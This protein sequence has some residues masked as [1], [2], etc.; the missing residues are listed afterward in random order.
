MRV[1]S[2]DL[3]YK[4]HSSVGWGTEAKTQSPPLPLVSESPSTNS[5]LSPSLSTSTENSHIVSNQTQKD[6]PPFSL[7]SE[8]R[9]SKKEIN[10]DITILSPQAFSLIFAQ[11]PTWLFSLEP[12][13]VSK[14]CFP[15]F[16]TKTSFISFLERNPRCKLFLHLIT[17]AFRSTLMI[18]GEILPESVFLI[19]GS[20]SFGEKILKLYNLFASSWIFLCD[21]VGQ[22]RKIPNSSSMDLHRARHSNFGGPT[23]GEVLWSCSDPQF[24]LASSSIHR[25]IGDFLDYS[26]RPSSVEC[27]CT[28]SCVHFSSLIPVRKLSSPVFYPSTYTR[29]GFGSR[30]LVSSELGLIF[31]LPKNFLQFATQSSF[32]FPPCQVLDALL[33][34][35]GVHSKW[36]SRPVR[37]ERPS[38]VLCTPAPVLDDEPTYLATLG[39]TL[40]DTWKSNIDASNAAAKADDAAINYSLWNERIIS[41][42][43]HA[44]GLLQPLREFILRSQKRRLYLEFLRYLRRTY[45]RSYELYLRSRN[46]LYASAGSREHLRGGDQ[47][48]LSDLGDPNSAKLCNLRNDIEDGI[49]VLNSY[50]GSSF[51]AWDKGS[52]LIFWRWHHQ[53]QQIAHHGFNAQISGTL[54]SNFKYSRKPSKQVH[55]KLFSKIKKGMERSY[56]KVTAKSRIKNLIDYFAVPKAEDIRMVQNG[57]SCGLNEATWASNFW[58]PTS[59]SMIRV[60]GFNYKAIDIDLGEM[61]LNFP[62]D[63]SLIPYS[64]MDITPFI[65]DVK[66]AFP[67]LPLPDKERLFV[68]NTRCWMGLRPSPEWA[69]R[70]YYL[71]EEF[72]RG[73]E[74]DPSN[75]LF[76]DKVV[77]NLI[78]NANFNPSM[79]N[80]YKWNSA[81]KRIAGDI[82]AYVDDLRA[83][84]WSMEHAWQI[85]H[86]VASRL[87]YLGIQDA[88]R[89][90][91]ID[92]G[93]WAGCVYLTSITKVQRTVTAKKWKKGQD[94]IKELNELVY[95]KKQTKLDF[96]FLEKVRGFLC[97]I[98]MTFDILFPFLKGFHLTLCSYL[99]KR[100]GEGW[101]IRDL[102]W[103]AFLEQEKFEG[104]MTEQEVDSL[105]KF[106]YDPKNRPHQIIPVPR[107]YS[108]LKALSTFFSTDDPPV[109]TDRSSEVKLLVYGFVDASKSGFGA[110][111]DYNNHV[112]FRIGI[113]GSDEDDASSNFREFAN[114]VETLEKEVKENRLK[115]AT[116]IMATD[117]STVEAAIQKGNSSSEKLFDLVVRF[118]NMELTSGSKFLVTH[119]SGDRMQ[120]QGTDGISRGSLREGIS[121]GQSMLKFCPWGL[122]ALTRST[123]LKEWIIKLIGPEIEILSPDDWFRRGHDHLPGAKDD[124]GFYRLKIKS[125]T[126]LW[127]P[128][129]AAAD[130]ALEELRKARLK[131]RNSTHVLLI[132]KLVTTLWL[133]QL[134]KAADVVLTIPPNFDFWP[135]NM[136]EPLYLAFVFPYSRH[137][138]WQLRS[139]PKLIATQRSL[140]R[141]LRAPPVAPRD[142]LRKFYLSTKRIPTLPARLVRKVLFF[143]SN[144]PLPCAPS[145]PV[146]H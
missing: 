54:P 13:M 22:F 6:L 118:R 75:P 41:V 108:C 24:S 116:V 101:K 63:R 72:V 137:Y 45:G 33:R 62:L 57:S 142:L 124:Q 119:V 117:N 87:Q 135:S 92:N 59:S 80:V 32:P 100:S 102:E 109:I 40:P 31:G 67:N 107:F 128:P 30:S 69:C 21:K 93:P 20:I 143:E 122:S 7:E 111:L 35:F 58:L 23:N 48:I 11:P 84:G 15:Q 104:R 14:M 70:F 36:S 144:D 76:W 53:L 77:L 73:D 50:H 49:G 55:A 114:L 113:W 131:R 95:E 115:D 46:Y 86:L 79:P 146:E 139:T 18:F 56:L 68:T 74:S 3:P 10:G 44:E 123:T 85:A 134:Y 61:F 97:H 141:M 125:G 39:M 51:F 140:H 16:A 138:P 98:A 52:T 43:P 9:R 19:E 110:S 127:H 120:S 129:P 37:R 29:T 2:Q 38:S 91:R 4:P 1:P 5:N 65:K 89:K 145:E 27:N 8:S 71:A 90:R 136:H 88:P 66:Q 105:L 26:L 82:K 112:R 17:S 83:L 12:A 106:K 60:L 133:R 126:F 78:G 64:G 28:S 121:L 47:K 96:K 132:P 130:V 81:M 25:K 34:Q 42:L 99:P 94:Y 103:I